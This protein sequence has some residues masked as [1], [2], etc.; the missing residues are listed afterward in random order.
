M[1]YYSNMLLTLAS[2]IHT[3]RNL[4][5]TFSHNKPL[6]NFSPF[7][8]YGKNFLPASVNIEEYMHHIEKGPIGLAQQ[9]MVYLL[10]GCA[11][12]KQKYVTTP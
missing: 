5:K 11:T 3:R 1:L 7:W 2:L 12:Q 10:C 9:R 8:L 6:E 4:H